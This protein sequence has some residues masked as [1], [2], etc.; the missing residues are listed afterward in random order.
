MSWPRMSVL[1][2]YIKIFQT[3]KLNQINNFTI[4]TFRRLKMYS[5]WIFLKVYLN[6]IKSEME[7][8]RNH[9]IR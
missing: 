7:L 2:A 5:L 4:Q 1:D 6:E 3:S 8:Y 9:A